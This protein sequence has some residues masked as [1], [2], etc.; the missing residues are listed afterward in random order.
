MKLKSDCITC[1]VW[2][3]AGTTL[4]CSKADCKECGK[5]VTG[6]LSYCACR[7]CKHL[8]NK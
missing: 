3:N 1:E 5:D 2:R 7:N 4:L 8:R 6:K